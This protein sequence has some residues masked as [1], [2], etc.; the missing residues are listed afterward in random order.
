MPKVNFYSNLF[1]TWSKMWLGRIIS[2]KLCP[3]SEWISEQKCQI[4]FL[5]IGLD[6]KNLS[7]YFVLNKARYQFLRFDPMNENSHCV[8]WQ[9]VN[10]NYNTVRS[11]H[12]KNSLSQGIWRVIFLMTQ[13]TIMYKQGIVETAQIGI[14]VTASQKRI[15]PLIT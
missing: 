4:G 1:L 11:G 14:F 10:K 13:I 6:K 2:Y 15:H 9:N 5:A 12:S 7:T 3:I 8:S